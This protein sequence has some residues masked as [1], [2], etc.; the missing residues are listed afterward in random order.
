VKTVGQIN[1]WFVLV[2]CQFYQRRQRTLIDKTDKE[3][4]IQTL[5]KFIQLLFYVF[6]RK[7]FK[8]ER[9]KDDDLQNTHI[10]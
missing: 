10:F 5:S 2:V 1:F 6:F 8:E 4:K 9:R 7:L 3:Y